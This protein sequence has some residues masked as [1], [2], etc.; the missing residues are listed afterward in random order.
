[1]ASPPPSADA[2]S[3]MLRFDAV[4]TLPPCGNAVQKPTAAGPT[5]VTF[6]TTARVVATAGSGASPVTTMLATPPG[7]RAPNESRVSSNRVGVGS[8]RY[9]V[10]P[11]GA[12]CT[13]DGAPSPVEMGTATADNN[14]TRESFNIRTATQGTGPNTPRP[15]APGKRGPYHIE[16]T[17]TW[18]YRCSPVVLPVGPIGLSRTCAC[19]G[20]RSC[21]KYHV[22]RR[23][24]CPSR[25]TTPSCS[26]ARSSSRY[27]MQ[28]SG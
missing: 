21:Q 9:A 12:A 8:G 28:C 6:T 13:T 14:A 5:T 20:V 10:V 25:K 4:G 24:P 15:C 1:M 26:K 19:I 17:G 18:R 23:L 2:R 16:E 22:S 27:P 3:S 7:P 11:A